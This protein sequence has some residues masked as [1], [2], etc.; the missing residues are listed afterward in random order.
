[1]A[2]KNT[3]AMKQ[4]DYDLLMEGFKDPVISKLQYLDL[5]GDL[6]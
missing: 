5:I 6:Y 2:A 3:L 1:M 4:A